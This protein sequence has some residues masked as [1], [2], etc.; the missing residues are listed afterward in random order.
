MSNVV[1]TF[2]TVTQS[3]PA[4]TTFGNF[5]LTLTLENAPTPTTLTGTAAKGSTV[6][7]IQNVPAG[8]YSATLAAVD[9]TG[10]VLGTPQT[11]T[12]TVAAPATVSINVPASLSLAVQ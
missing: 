3:F 5:L 6:V 7:E 11:G 12:V 9:P 10:V 2:T 1:A 8:T 4:G